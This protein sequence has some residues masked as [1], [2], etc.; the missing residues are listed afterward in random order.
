MKYSIYFYKTNS[1]DNHTTGVIGW[2]DNIEYNTLT[3]AQAAL[4]V[5][6][7]ELN[8]DMYNITYKD[9]LTLIA[10]RTDNKPQPTTDRVVF[11]ICLPQSE[12]KE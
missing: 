12:L 10:E 5:L 4:N 3:K 1:D 9:S 2:Y 8:N 11:S 7:D 6:V